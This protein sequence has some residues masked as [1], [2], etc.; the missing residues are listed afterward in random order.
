MRSERPVPDIDFKYVLVSSLAKRR[1]DT[2]T[3]ELEP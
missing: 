1:K 2:G 3:P